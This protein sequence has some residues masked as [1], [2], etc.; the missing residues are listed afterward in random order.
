[1]TDQGRHGRGQRHET[2]VDWLP[3]GVPEPPLITRAELLEKLASD[4]VTVS[5]RE[6]RYWETAGAL[7]HPVR[8][9]HQGAIHAVY[10]AWHD[11]IVK[12]VPKL[13]P[14]MKLPRMRP[15]LR[16]LFQMTAAGR[17]DQGRG[18]MPRPL[19]EELVRFL[20]SIGATNAELR[21]LAGN[22][23]KLYHLSMSDKMPVNDKEIVNRSNG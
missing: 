6:L 18:D 23:I 22:Q 1:M 21:V 3:T 13:R 19:A 8:R 15:E 5:E 11:E 9:S 16:R 14:L 20:A 10:P 17:Q 4:G 7:P 12:E 2:W